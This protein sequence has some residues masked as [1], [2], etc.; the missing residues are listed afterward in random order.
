M[1]AYYTHTYA[2]DYICLTYNSLPKGSWHI[3]QNITNNEE[4]PRDCNIHIPTHIGDFIYNIAKINVFI[5]NLVSAAKPSSSVRRHHQ[6]KLELQ[7]LGGVLH[8]HYIT[9]QKT[10]GFRVIKLTN[11]PNTNHESCD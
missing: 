9:L 10:R 11:K 5:V 2:S 3:F 4:I 6:Q 7:P 8:P 1:L